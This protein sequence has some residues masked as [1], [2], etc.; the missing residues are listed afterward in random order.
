MTGNSADTSNVNSWQKWLPPDIG[1]NARERIRVA[2]GAMLG[3][4]IAALLSRWLGSA[5]AGA[6]L[7]AP[8]GASAVLVFALPASPLAQ[9]WPVLVG[10]TLSAVVGIVC[11]TWIEDTVLAATVAVGVAMLLMFVTRSLHPPGGAVA[12][13]A[14]LSGSHSL[15]FALFPVATNTLLLLLVGVVYNRL[16]G[17]RY[18]HVT[19]TVASPVATRFTAA[20][21][22]AALAHYNQVVDIS[23]DD[24]AELLGYAEA[25]AYQRRLGDLR[26]AD[27]M[28]RK[29]ITAD[30]AMLL[31]QAWQLMRHHHIKALPVV[32]RSQRLL[33]IVTT[34]DFMKHAQVDA[35]GTAAGRLQKLLQPTPL[36]HTN[37][38]E[39][40]GQIMTRKVRVASVDRPLVDLLPLL[41][42]G[43]YHHIPIIEGDNVLVGI[44]TQTDLI[45]A[46]Y[47]ATAMQS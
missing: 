20:D 12:L 6:W 23:R 2:V 22:D 42:E 8:L 44:I 37:K 5:Q 38:P 11:A 18:P 21:L 36:T 35:V 41:A 31:E 10:N 47:A 33:G 40:V 1:G 9:P 15:W 14:V 25:Q 28:T 13:F 26:C 7:M 27:I 16:T 3:I 34:A 45:R 24:L 17:K 46:L 43:G 19:V 32:D 29:V 4:F 30:Y 39:A